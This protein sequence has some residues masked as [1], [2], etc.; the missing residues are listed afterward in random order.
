MSNLAKVFVTGATGFIGS[1][2]VDELLKKNYQVKCLVRQTSNLR[3]LKGKRVELIHGELF[4]NDIIK[5]AVSDV[6]YIYHAAGATSSKTKAGYYIA[7]KEA[8]RSLIKN[9]YE[10]NHKLKKF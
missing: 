1:I 2:L 5:G 10:V 6:D 7:N 9:T 8:T 4:D 3:W